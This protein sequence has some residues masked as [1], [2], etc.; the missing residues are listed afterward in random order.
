MRHSANSPSACQ[1]VTSRQPNSVGSN[2]FHRCITISPPMAMTRT[3]PTT[4]T[5]ARKSHFFLISSPSCLRPFVVDRLQSLAQMEHRVALAR[6]QRVQADAALRGHLP[7]A[8]AFELV[9]HEHLAL[10]LR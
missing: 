7:E 4:A 2:Q 10:L 3:I 1:N 5:G 8:A 6:E 9:G